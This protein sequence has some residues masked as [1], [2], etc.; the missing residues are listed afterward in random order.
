MVRST[1]MGEG[2]SGADDLVGGQPGDWLAIGWFTPDYR[3]LAETF[4]AKLAEQGAPFHV[5]ARPKVAAGWNTAQK[6]DVVLHAMAMYPDKT[7]V[8]MDLDCCVHG[9]ISP[10]VDMPGDVGI[11]VIARNLPG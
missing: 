8:L 5:F 3:P 9:D 6:P 10:M 4:A 7:L 2:L 1:D 11:T